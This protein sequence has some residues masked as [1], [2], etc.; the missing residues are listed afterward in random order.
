M[1][2]SSMRSLAARIRRRLL[3]QARPPVAHDTPGAPVATV[4]F[5]CNICGGQNAAVPL[6]HVQ[7]RE[8]QSCAYCRSSLRMRSVMYALTMEIYGKG[9]VIGE[10]PRD[11][12]LVGL[13]MSDWEGYAD[14][15]ADKFSYTN[16]F[17]H[18]SPHLDITAIPTELENKHDF[19]ISSDVFEHIPVF[20]LEQAFE[21]SRKLLK[22]GGVFIFTVPFVKEGETREHFPHLHDFRII[23]TGNKRFLYNVTRDGKEE[24]FDDL[25]FHGGDGMT[26]EMR[27]FSETDLYRR[28]KKAGFDSIRTYADCVPEFGILWPM[29]WAVP[30]VARTGN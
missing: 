8:Y 27:M 15:L 29:D 13:G 16:T 23:E 12:S 25:V 18:T 7:N 9:L 2:S 14:R 22:Q 21:N 6:L 26:L 20:A 28:L 19:M 17:Y 3:S 1:L 5:L 11:K 30:I 10:C 4:D 24:I